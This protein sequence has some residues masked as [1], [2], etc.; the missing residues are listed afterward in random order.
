MFST[1]SFRGEETGRILRPLLAFL[2]PW[3]GEE[4]LGAAHA[5]ARKLGHFTEYAILAALVFRARRQPSRSVLQIVLSTILL[6]ALY[7]CLDEFHQS[8]VPSRTGAATDVA[9]DSAGAV[10]GALFA[11]WW[12]GALSSDRRLPV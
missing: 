5:A 8:F 9:L 3:T 1:D 11:A 10:T 2:L 12:A 7:A 4:T 6:C